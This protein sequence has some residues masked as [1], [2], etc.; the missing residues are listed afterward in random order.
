MSRSQRLVLP[1]SAA[2]M[3]ALWLEPHGNGENI[4]WPIW[5]E[6]LTPYG[7]CFWLS[8][9]YV[10]WPFLQGPCEWGYSWTVTLAGQFCPIVCGRLQDTKPMAR[11]IVGVGSQS[12]QP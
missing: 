2:P 4:P 1:L 6:H 7:H 12:S 5:W 11:S 8:Y 10:S 9:G 3:I